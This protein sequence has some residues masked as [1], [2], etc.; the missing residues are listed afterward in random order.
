[1]AHPMDNGIQAVTAR[2]ARLEQRFVEDTGSTDVDTSSSSST[3]SSTSLSA[4]GFASVLAAALGTTALGI[5]GAD[6]STGLG[7]AALGIGTSGGNSSAL[8]GSSLAG[9]TIGGTGVGGS[10]LAGNALA[11]VLGGTTNSSALGT[12]LTGASGTAAL[13]A[14]Q[15]LTAAVLI[16]L[17][18]AVARGGAWTSGA[19]TSGGLGSTTAVGA[20]GRTPANK[21]SP[22]AYPKLTPP[23]ELAAYGNGRIPSERLQSIGVGS[24]KLYAPA[25]TAYRQM[26]ADAAAQG[27]KI[28]ITDSYRSYDSQVELAGRKGLYSQGGLAATPGTSNHGWGL[29]VDLDLDATAQQWMRDHAHEYGFVEDTPREPWHWGYRP[30]ASV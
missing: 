10:S 27:V 18:S 3:A 2:I 1:M 21:L 15:Q 8:G 6:S 7:T 23:A 25:A 12:G 4:G 26:T 11:S 29:A 9:T 20:T 24:H 22:G 30:A 19:V 28:G 17:L 14:N 16:S 13:G 5:D